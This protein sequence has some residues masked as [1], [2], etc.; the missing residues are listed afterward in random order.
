MARGPRCSTTPRASLADGEPF[1]LILGW[2][3]PHE[4]T[5]AMVQ[6]SR[7]SPIFAQRGAK[8]LPPKYFSA[9]QTTTAVSRGPNPLER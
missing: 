4:S 3:L 8:C 5:G 1:D 2:A 7:S 9:L 6:G